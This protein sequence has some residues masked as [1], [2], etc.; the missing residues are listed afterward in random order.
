MTLI[1]VKGHEIKSITIKDSANRRAIQFKNNILTTLRALGLT[2]DDV[3]IELERVAIKRT[4][5]SAT[6]YFDGYRMHYS[7]NR[8][9][10]Y[11]ENLY[12]V[13]KVIEYE[14]LA[15]LAEEK[16]IEEFIRAFSEE[17]EVEEERA[18]A[19]ELL[20]VPAD[21]NDLDLINKTYKK[22]AKTAH[23]D[24]ESGDT[25]TFKA[26]NRAHKILKRELN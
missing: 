15:V 20:G 6:W 3:E 11:V 21:C 14:V 8:A 19:R 22:L 18:A 13:S 7:Y 10:K 26:L 23:P 1:K 5:A 17:D 2:E 24:M 16:T 9:Q 25:E 4:G 12:I